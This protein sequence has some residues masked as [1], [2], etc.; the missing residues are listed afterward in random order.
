[1]SRE[2]FELWVRKNFNFGVRASDQY[3]AISRATKDLD[4]RI[5]DRD[6]EN[7]QYS[8]RK[9]V[10]EVTENKNF[11]KPAAWRADIAD[12]IRKAKA[13]AR[14]LEDE[15]LS[16][17]EERKA[18][19]ALAMRLI[20]IGFKVLAKELHPDRGGSKDAMV[21]LGKVRARLKTHA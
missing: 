16:Q 14:R 3:I 12:N 13:D 1:M 11:G 21:R 9:M 7:E 19:K 4:R 5:V 20:D 18:E 2:E 15:R 6:R 10:R 17:A 8:F